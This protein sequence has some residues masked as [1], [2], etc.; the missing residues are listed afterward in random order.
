M[1][2][3]RA[4]RIAAILIVAVAATVVQVV[5]LDRARAGQDRTLFIYD[6][7]GLAVFG[8]LRDGQFIQLQTVDIGSGWTHAAASR[9]TLMLYNKNTGYAKTGLVGGGM[10]WGD[11]K[12]RYV[13]AGWTHLTAS[14][15]SFMLYQ[16][17]SGYY[18]QGRLQSGYATE[19]YYGPGF[20]TGWDLIDASCDTIHFRKGATEGVTA[21][22]RLVG[23][24]FSQHG[25]SYFGGS[26]VITHMTHTTTSFLQ[27]AKYESFGNWGP[28]TNGTDATA[29][30]AAFDFSTSWDILAGTENTVIF[31][32]KDSGLAAT[33]YLSG[34]Q[35]AFSRTYGFSAGWDLMAGAK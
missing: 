3:K 31:Y 32:D 15:D 30:G 23:G 16:R 14:C 27:L 2:G 9:D 35:Y 18:M 11:V 29:Y 22:G 5:G 6:N 26:R 8:S 13:G 1:Q 24:Y 12:T 10:Y 4:R 17:S 34:S 25:S 20:S 33:S 28:A 7:G 21:H 19:T